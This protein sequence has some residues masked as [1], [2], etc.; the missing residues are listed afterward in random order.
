MPTLW[1]K[2][3]VISKVKRINNC[4]L[5]FSLWINYQYEFYC[6]LD[7]EGQY[8]EILLKFLHPFAH[9]DYLFSSLRGYTWVDCLK[10]KKKKSLCLHVYQ[11][12]VCAC[13]CDDVVV[14]RQC[15]DM[16]G[17][18][19]KEEGQ[20]CDGGNILRRGRGNVSTE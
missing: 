20:E 9:P 17:I 18:L 1:Q 19:R 15:K 2:K 4:N 8:Y 12:G 7:L 14:K 13:V 3:T 10:K 6:C 16:T 11:R 5:I